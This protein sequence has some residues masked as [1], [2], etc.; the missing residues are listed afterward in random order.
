MKENELNY[1][2]DIHIDQD[3]LDQEWRNQPE[4]FLQYAQAAVE[5]RSEADRT[6]EALAIAKAAADACIRDTEGKKPT[7]AAI[8]SAVL[9]DEDVQEATATNNAAW[10]RA[11]MLQVAKEAF[12]HRKAA[13]ENLVRL[14]GQQYFSSPHVSGEEGE[15]GKEEVKHNTQRRQAKEVK[16]ERGNRTK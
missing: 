3:R 14:Y 2:D 15:R 5:A 1:L 12:E 13:L 7:E 8:V 11:G 4:L 6:K 10:E 9:L 16:R